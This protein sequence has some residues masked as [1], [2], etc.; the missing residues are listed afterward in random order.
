MGK[1]RRHRVAFCLNTSFCEVLPLNVK[2]INEIF[3]YV[4]FYNKWP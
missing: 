3:Q 4:M 2:A 1:A